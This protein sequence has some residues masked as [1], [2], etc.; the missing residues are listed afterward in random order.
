MATEPLSTGK[1]RI[2]RIKFIRFIVT[3]TPRVPSLSM[4]T[5]RP[6]GM[7]RYSRIFVLASECWRSHPRLRRS[8]R[9]RWAAADEGRF[10][11]DQPGSAASLGQPQH[12]PAGDPLR[13]QPES[14]RSV[15][16]CRIAAL[17]VAV[18][19]VVS[20]VPALRCE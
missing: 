12:E 3:E 14:R 13:H 1:A 15:D 8:S 4:A 9:W 10:E 16:F 19:L 7:N 5:A 6:K 11:R 20:Y 2:S 17:L 18:T